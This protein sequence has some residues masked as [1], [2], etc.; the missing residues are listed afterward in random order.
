MRF[1]ATISDQTRTKTGVYT[2]PPVKEHTELDQIIRAAYP[3][4]PDISDYS[5]VWSVMD[6]EEWTTESLEIIDVRISDLTDNDRMAFQAWR[7]G[8]SWPGIAVVMAHL[9]E[10]GILQEGLH[11]IM[12]L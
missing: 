9:A 10:Q 2:Y 11:T 1:E 3:D 5:S 6:S 8:E 4:V 7:T 12:V